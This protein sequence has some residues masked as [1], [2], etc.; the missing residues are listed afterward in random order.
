VSAV[1]A[2]YGWG[3][4][5]G[6]PDARRHVLRDDWEFHHFQGNPDSWHAEFRLSRTVA[7][8]W[9]VC[10]VGLQRKTD[11]PDGTGSKACG[12]CV[13]PGAAELRHERVWPAA[14]L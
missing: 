8:A 5:A 2:P 4:P 9:A 1:D 14:E 11:A 10:G 13:T 6:E 3:V 7:N 12:V